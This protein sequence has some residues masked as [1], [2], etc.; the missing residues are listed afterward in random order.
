MLTPYDIETRTFERKMRGYN[1]DEVNEF[2]KLVLQDYEKLYKENANLKSKMTVLVEKI[3]EYKKI[4]GSLRNAL[5][6]AQKMGETMV[7]DANTKAELILNEAGIKA[8]RLINSLNIQVYKEKQKLEEARRDNQL[9]RAKLIGMY[10]TQMNLLEGIPGLSEEEK[11]NKKIAEPAKNVQEEQADKPEIKT[12]EKNEDDE[13][14]REIKFSLEYGSAEDLTEEEKDD[15]EEKKTSF[16][17]FNK[18]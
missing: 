8:E 11:D 13:L 1:A 4:E 16:F 14:T 12:E 7:K 5:V 9:F 10:K 18:E 6:S 15:K 3:E 17:S 2:M